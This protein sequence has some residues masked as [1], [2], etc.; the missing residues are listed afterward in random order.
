MN[1][2]K[3]SES[4]EVGYGKPPKRTQ[5]QKGLSGNPNGRP[6]GTLNFTTVFLRTLREKVVTTENGKKKIIT[7]LEASLKQ[8]VNQAASGDLRAVSQV[9]AMAISAEQSANQ[10]MTQQQQGLNE[11][12]QKVVLNILKRYNTTAGG[13][14]EDEKGPE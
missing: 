1:N 12:D 14:T 3:S 4:Y 2:E 8:L 5:F 6:K 13:S 11:L 10:D 9:A 7:K